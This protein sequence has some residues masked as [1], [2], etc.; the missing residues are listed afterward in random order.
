MMYWRERLDGLLYGEK[1]QKLGRE[2]GLKSK[3]TLRVEWKYKTDDELE[4]YF[5][6]PTYGALYWHRGVLINDRA[7]WSTPDYA[8]FRDVIGAGEGK[9]RTEIQAISDWVSQNLPLIVAVDPLR[10]RDPSQDLYSESDGDV[11][12]VC[13]II[14]S[15]LGKQSQFPTPSNGKIAAYPGDLTLDYKN[16]RTKLPPLSGG[17]LRGGLPDSSL[18]AYLLR[19]T[20]NASQAAIGAASR[21]GAVSCEVVDLRPFQLDAKELAI[22]WLEGKIEVP[23]RSISRDEN[24]WRCTEE[25]L[26]R[27]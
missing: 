3:S 12:L 11:T 25:L 13:G 18:E 26:K 8:S 22:L 1:I 6:V 17:R 4:A 15:A 16:S 7:L 20:H 27:P 21:R 23:F 19:P 2:N 5:E 24:G 10:Q 9:S 14:A